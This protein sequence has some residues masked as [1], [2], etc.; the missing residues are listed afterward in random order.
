M[1]QLIPLMFFF[2]FFPL[3]PHFLNFTLAF[4][5]PSYF[6]LF[7]LRCSLMPPQ[8]YPVL[9]LAS[10]LSSQ[11]SLSHYL[12]TQTNDWI[13]SCRLA[14]SV[15]RGLAYLHTEL[16]K[17]GKLDTTQSYQSVKCA[18]INLYHIKLKPD[19]YTHCIKRCVFPLSK[20]MNSK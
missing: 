2:L 19:V 13:R 7:P 5:F 16:C 1:K 15:T 4:Y 9:S 18:Q 20:G 11:G 14:H 17:G 6:Y 12:G 3:L 10:Y 8:I